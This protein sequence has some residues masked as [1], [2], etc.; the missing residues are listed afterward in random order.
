MARTADDRREL[1][2]AFINERGLK[3]AR[4]A[5]D[6]GVDKN[7]IY[8]FLNGHSQALDPRTYA[9]LAR[10]VEVPSWK[11]T[12]DQPEPPSPTAIW[13]T[14]YV[15]AGAFREAIEWDSSRW[16]AVDVPVPERFR[17][18]ARALEVRGVSM[19]LEY[20]PGSIVIW[21]DYLDFRPPR[22]EDHVIVYSHHRDGTVEATVKELRIA[23]D[24]RRWL[25]PRSSH[26]EHQ[27][28]VDIENPPEEIETIELRGIVVGDYRP[29]EF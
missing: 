1:L 2:R 20:R 4:W 7:S 22:H 11:L 27:A 21:V 18:R 26:P 5:K 14:G 9:K 28:P 3:I 15:E 25:W 8:N 16:Y 6:S 17:K 13:V 10:T 24:G 29:R 12:G 23:D 19:D